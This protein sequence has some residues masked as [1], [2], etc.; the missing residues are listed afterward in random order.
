MLYLSH[1]SSG[2]IAAFFVRKLRDI[3]N[4]QRIFQKLMKNV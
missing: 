4:Y 2:N 3:K 1:T